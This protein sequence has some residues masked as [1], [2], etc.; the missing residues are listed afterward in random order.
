[1]DRDR[2]TALWVRSLNPGTADDVD[3]VFSKV[4]AHYSESHRRYHTPQH[5][6]HCLRQFDLALAQV[7]QQDAVEMA[8]WFHDII[9]NIPPT[10]NELKSAELFRSITKDRIDPTLGQNVYDMILITMHKVT[11]TRN[12]EKLLVDVD[13]SS[14]AL[15]WEKFKKDSENVRQ[16]FSDKSDRDFYSAHM[17]FMQSLLDRPSFFSSD[18]FQEKCEANARENVQRLIEELHCA[19]FS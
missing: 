12:D 6:V 3:E 16:E 9:Y 4:L 2:F 8:I 14:F 5:I 11:P 18:F 19:G 10:Q 15:P 7:E 13:L 17:K 1:M